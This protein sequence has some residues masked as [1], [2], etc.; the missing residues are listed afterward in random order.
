MQIFNNFA[1]SPA[2]PEGDLNVLSRTFI[3]PFLEIRRGAV[4]IDQTEKVVES[5]Q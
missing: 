4:I 5:I 2:P 3:A 1:G